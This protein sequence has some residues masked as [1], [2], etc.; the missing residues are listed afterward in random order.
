MARLTRGL[1]LAAGV[2]A[3]ALG[4]FLFAVPA[5]IDPER[6]IPPKAPGLEGPAA[7]NT[8]LQD[9][10]LF[11]L[12][13]VEGPED[14]AIDEEGRL[15]TGGEDGTVYRLTLTDDGETLDTVESFAETGGR[16]YGMTFHEGTLYVAAGDAG[17]VAVDEDGSVT[18]L[19]ATAGGE[20][21]LFADDLDVAEDGT[22]YFSDAS[23]Y[24]QYLY[25]LLEAKP[26]GRLIAYHPETEETEV[27]M[28]ELYF[29]NGVTLGPGEQFLL[30]NET[31][32]YRVRRYWLEGEYEGQADVFA[33]NLPGFP[34]N[35]N[36]AGD[37][38]FWVACPALRTAELDDIQQRPFLKKQLAKLPLEPLLDAAAEEYG[39]VLHLDA[40]GEII[41]SLHDP[42]G[43]LHS[44]TSATPHGDHLYLGTLEGD[45]VGRYPL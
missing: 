23:I 30:V 41:E 27:L 19:A 38:T 45:G 6:W 33:R 28:P 11:E 21:I 43:R 37:G 14:V 35:V 10:T 9:A 5:P 2:G 36:H 40:E 44:L 42:S 20:P 39:L 1:S 34:D 16:P 15:Y 22:V 13:G 31:P 29:A 4:G 25:D 26:H 12:E 24:E 3:A 17:L 7:E 8:R 18:T 32:R